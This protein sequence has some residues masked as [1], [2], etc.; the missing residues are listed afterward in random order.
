MQAEVASPTYRA[1]LW[2]HGADGVLD[3]GKLTVG[4]L[5]AALDAGVRVH[6]RSPVTADR[7]GVGQRRRPDRARAR[8]A[9]SA[10]CSPRACSR[11]SCARSAPFIVPVYDY[12]LVT[13][14]LSAAQRESIGWRRRQ[15]LSRRRQPVP[16]L[17]ADARRPD[18]VGRLRRGLSLPRAGARRPRRPRPDVRAP[19]AELLH[20]L[21]PARGPPLHAPLGRRDRHLQPLLGL[22]RHGARRPPGLRR[23]LHRAWASA[24]RASAPAS[25]STSST[26]A[27]PRRPGPATCA[28]SRSRS[29]PSRSAPR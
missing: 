26:G 15:G 17:P 4:L 5:R 7:R 23:R 2:V 24:P 14:P 8:C 20:D 22:L 12:V 19:V 27:T 9:P 11:R 1:G 3:P 13:E 10:W 25:R 16:L 18:P 29:R 21:P 6:E 28:A